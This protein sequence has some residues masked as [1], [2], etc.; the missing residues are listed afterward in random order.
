M[1]ASGVI[2]LAAGLCEAAVSDG[3]GPQIRDVRHRSVDVMG[4]GFAAARRV[5]RF[6]NPHRGR[7]PR[8][9]AARLHSRGNCSRGGRVGLFFFDPVSRP[10]QDRA[11]TA[12][13][14][15]ILTAVNTPS[16]RP[17]ADVQSS[18]TPFA[19][20]C[21]QRVGDLRSYRHFNTLFRLP[22]ALSLV[23]RSVRRRRIGPRAAAR[24]RQLGD[25]RCFRSPAMPT[26]IR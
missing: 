24:P 23:R 18:R 15:H 21:G 22:E 1:C 26:A 2:A 12:A 16:A 8:D 14:I 3:E 10:F 6:R 17:T 4:G 9:A 19:T 5:R 20:S 7:A 11:E 25:A 13:P